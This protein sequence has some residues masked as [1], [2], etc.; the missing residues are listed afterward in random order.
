M[1]PL[2]VGG[3]GGGAGV[4]LGLKGGTPQAIRKQLFE[5]SGSIVEKLKEK[6]GG[7]LEG[8]TG[9]AVG[10]LKDQIL[11]LGRNPE[12]IGLEEKQGQYYSK[13]T[14]PFY[15]KR[16]MLSWQKNFMKST[17]ERH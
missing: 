2:Q 4:E 8:K 5:G 3:G 15:L 12:V 16:D 17:V 10:E 7:L 13:E 14:I 9:M 11:G 6:L 1:S